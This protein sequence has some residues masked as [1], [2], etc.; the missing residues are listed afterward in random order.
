VKGDAQH[1]HAFAQVVSRASQGSGEVGTCL[2]LARA[3]KGCGCN[4]GK[5]PIFMR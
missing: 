3:H 4:Y 2:R 1:I 5:N